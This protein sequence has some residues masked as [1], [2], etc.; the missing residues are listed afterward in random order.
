MIFFAHRGSPRFVAENTVKSFLYA[1]E[2]GM[3][4]FETD[5]RFIGGQCLLSHDP[6]PPGEKRDS[7]SAL[8]DILGP[9]DVLN[10]ELKTED[11][12]YPG[13]EEAVLRV[14]QKHKKNIIFSSFNHETLKKIRS[15]DSEVKIGVLTR[16]FYA[17]RQ[18][19]LALGAYSVNINKTRLTKEICAL[20]RSAGQKVFVYTVNTLAELYAAEAAGADGVFTDTPFLKDDYDNLK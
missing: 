2:N 11:E 1:K 12:Q 5:A 15:L 19:A 8:L 17:D 13:I 6:V 10:V 4:F 14:T 7:L 3:T 20:A 18:T 9:G 16:D